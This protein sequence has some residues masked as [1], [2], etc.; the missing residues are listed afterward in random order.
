MLIP[1]EQSP[2]NHHC[3]TDVNSPGK[4]VCAGSVRITVFVI[5]G[6]NEKS[7]GMPGLLL[8]LKGV[9]KETL[10]PLKEMTE[11]SPGWIGGH[12]D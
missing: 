9:V 2:V 1:R 11:P 7:A 5:D 3:V 8:G 10:M 4:E 6:L 12:I